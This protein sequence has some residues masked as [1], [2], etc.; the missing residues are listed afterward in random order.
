METFIA[1]VTAI[2]AV[3]AAIGLLSA[4]LF[5]LLSLLWDDLLESDEPVEVQLARVA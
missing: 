4:G 5:S 2:A 3:L 1:V